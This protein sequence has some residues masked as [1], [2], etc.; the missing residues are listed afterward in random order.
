MA[1]HSAEYISELVGYPVSAWLRGV[2][3]PYHD[4]DGEHLIGAN[5]Q[6]FYRWRMEMVKGGQIP[7]GQAKYVQPRKS[8][9]AAYLPRL[10][11][12]NW[13]EVAHDISFDIWLTEGEF[14][15]IRAVQE[16][17]LCVGLGGVDNWR[18]KNG[19]LARPLDKFMWRGRNV[20]ICFD[21]DSESTQ[22]HPLK[23][24]VEGAFQRISARFGELGAKVYRVSLARTETFLKARTE[25]LKCKMGLDDFFVAGGTGTELTDAKIIEPVPH[26]AVYARLLREYAI[27]MGRPPRVVRLSDG[28]DFSYTDFKQILEA[29][30]I[31]Y[32]KTQTPGGKMKIEKVLEHTRW[33]EDADR[34]EID[35]YEFMPGEEPGYSYETRA[36]NVWKGWK[37]PVEYPGMTER[38]NMVVKDWKT[39]LKGLFGEWDWYVEKWLAHMVQCPAE[40]TNI[41]ILLNSSLQGI[42]K[43]LLGELMVGIIGGHHAIAMQLDRVVG[44]NFNSLLEGKLFLQIDEAEGQFKGYEAKLSDLVTSEYVNIELKGRNAYPIENFVRLYMTSNAIVP[45]RVREKDRR[46]FVVVPQITYKMAEEWCPWVSDRIAK[47]I[48]RSP[49]GLKLLHWYLNKVDLTGWNPTERVPQTQDMKELA[50]ASFTR[51]SGMADEILEALRN[52]DRMWILTGE[53]RKMDSVLWKE[54]L[55]GIKTGGGHTVSHR[56]KHAGKTFAGVVLDPRDVYPRKLSDDQWFLDT[57]AW[58]VT[59]QECSDACQRARLV[60]EKI[61]S[62]HDRDRGHSGEPGYRGKY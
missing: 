20:I 29:P 27:Y 30:A 37:V 25:N 44:T 55:S 39:F 56:W 1:M 31:T 14:K 12:I 35:K 8:G 48:K 19:A 50:E 62:D 46:F 58:E 9:V 41:A 17:L 16:T 40:K 5:N 34:L 10:H 43:S 3:L 60:Y 61:C 13:V 36:F 59:G 51:K 7:E 6:V 33:L 38:Y 52:D 24:S 15:S 11:D 57:A 53:V 18:D 47:G 45:I 26:N 54:V 4:L 21:A 23:P 22:E 42:G 32:I 2:F 28:A 49:D